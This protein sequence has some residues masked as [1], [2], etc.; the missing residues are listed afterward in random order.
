MV[1]ETLWRFPVSLLAD[2]VRQDAA[3]DRQVPFEPAREANH[4]IAN[5]LALVASFARIQVKRA[6]RMPEGFQTLELCALMAALCANIEAIARLHRQLALAPAAD[7]VDAGPLLEEFCAELESLYSLSG[8]WTFAWH[9]GSDCVLAPPQIVSIS[10]I[11]AELVAN[12]VK[13][14]HPSGVA[15]TIS[16]DIR[17]ATVGNG[18]IVEVIDDGVGLPEGFDWRAQG[19]LGLGIVRALAAE[20]NASLT[21]DSN[22][23]GTAVRLHVPRA[24]AH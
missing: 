14:A 15:G 13:Y 24:A 12:A 16:I 22:A 21:M 9:V 6:Q 17:T 20:L 10:V 4:R 11:V 1:R 8:Q 18:V 3:L 2:P 23:L 5:N 19:N 7:T